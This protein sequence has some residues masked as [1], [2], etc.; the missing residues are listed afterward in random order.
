VEEILAFVRFWKKHT[1]ALPT[2]LVFD[3]RLTAYEKLSALNRLGIRLLTLR[4][5]SRK[6]LGQ[7]YGRRIWL[8]AGSTC[9]RRSPSRTHSTQP[10][11]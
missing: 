8:G 11:A 7:I 10:R 1:C 3:S 2:E 9:A 6:M 5:R 4:R